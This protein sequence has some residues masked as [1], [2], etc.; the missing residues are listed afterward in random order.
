V[1]FT[2]NQGENDLRMTKVQQKI[3]GCFRSMEGVKYFCWVRSYPS[4]YRKQSMMATEA[5][6]LLFQGK[7]P[8]FMKMHE[9]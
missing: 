6:T 4:T 2:N 1:P 9:A 5:L 8:D 3:S 7:K